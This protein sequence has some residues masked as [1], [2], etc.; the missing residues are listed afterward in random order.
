MSRGKIKDALKLVE[1]RLHKSGRRKKTNPRVF[2]KEE[3]TQLKLN[4]ARITTINPKKNTMGLKSQE[5][6]VLD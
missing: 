3:D 1:V 6:H 4:I 5:T 2:A